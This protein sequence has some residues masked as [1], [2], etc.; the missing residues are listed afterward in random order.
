MELL[1]EV[2]NLLKTGHIIHFG[3][4][5]PEA[6]AQKYFRVER[7]NQLVYDVS[8]IVAPG[9][10]SSGASGTD[11]AIQ[12]IGFDAPN[13]GAVSD[14]LISLLPTKDITMYEILLGFKGLGM[15]Y[16][17]FANRYQQQLETSLVLPTP[18]SSALAW[19]GFFDSQQSPWYAP[20]VRLYTV[21]DQEPPHLYLFNPYQDDEKIV[22]R[23]VVNKCKLVSVSQPTEQDKKV[24]RELTYY[25]EDLW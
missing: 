17:R 7:A 11:V 1:M 10:A 6:K 19:L 8:R 12:D 9:Y 20:K 24:A 23:F 16:P 5:W 4:A 15:V 14:A 22:A 18:S 3:N 25:T 2:P 21:K 13:A